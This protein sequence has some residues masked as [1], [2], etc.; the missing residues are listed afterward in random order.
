MT[1]MT[2]PEAIRGAGLTRYAASATAVARATTSPHCCSTGAA[3]DAAGSRFVS[4]FGRASKPR[5]EA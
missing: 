4:A 1:H 2:D 3:R 5:W